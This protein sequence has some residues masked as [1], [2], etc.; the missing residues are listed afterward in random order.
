MNVF[1]F[2]VEFIE[3]EVNAANAATEPA[4]N[5]DLTNLFIR[6]LL[7]EFFYLVKYGDQ[8]GNFTWPLL[9]GRLALKR[10]S[11]ETNCNT[12]PSPCVEL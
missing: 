11:A 3:T 2:D 6:F 8:A 1:T 9:P 12:F 7:N 4:T 10:P 5:N